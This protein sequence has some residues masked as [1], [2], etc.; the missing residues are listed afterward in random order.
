MPAYAQRS[1]L[2]SSAM[3]PEY[4]GVKALSD[5]QKSVPMGASPTATAP[6]V[7]RPTPGAAGSLTRPT[8]RPNEPITAGANFGPGPNA[9]GAGIPVSSSPVG[10]RD[11]LGLRLRAIA[12]QFPNAALLGLI[13]E[14]E[15]Q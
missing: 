1:D 10:G 2:N 15:S 5:A 4:G 8:E 11:D 6:Q 3:T 13:A 14:L 7:Q 12:S 9:M